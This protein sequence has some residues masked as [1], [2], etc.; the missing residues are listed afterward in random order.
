MDLLQELNLAHTDVTL[1]IHLKRSLSTI[2]NL[3]NHLQE[4]KQQIT[5]ISHHLEVHL[6][7]Q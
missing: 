7:R 3:M 4:D 1:S 5:L 2:N 6:P